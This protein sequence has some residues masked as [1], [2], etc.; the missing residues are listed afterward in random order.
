MLVVALV[1]VNLSFS[2][3]KCT[4]ISKVQAFEFFHERLKYVFSYINIID[5]S[6]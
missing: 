1:L 4:N 3:H 2:L 6:S 5:F